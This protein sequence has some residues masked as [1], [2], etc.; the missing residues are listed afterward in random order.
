M[1]KSKSTSYYKNRAWN[2]FSKYIRTRDCLATTGTIERGRC[3]TCGKI[4]DFRDLQAGHC[5][6]GR[7]KSILFDEELVN[8][9]CRGCNYFG[10]GKYA[11][12]TLWFIKKYGEKYW[13]EKVELSHQKVKYTKVDYQE[14]YE[15]YKNK[16]EKLLNEK[17]LHIS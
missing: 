4:F 7:Y 8:A 6:P 3:V 16:L 1:K 5:I 14:I 17:G 10:G 15:K 13:E 11:D 12:Y 9:Q 2:M